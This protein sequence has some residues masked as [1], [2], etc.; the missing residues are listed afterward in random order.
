MVG[1]V[2]TVD[3]NDRQEK[4]MVDFRRKLKREESDC[5]AACVEFA[6]HLRTNFNILKGHQFAAR[7]FVFDLTKE[8]RL[9]YPDLSLQVIQRV[10]RRERNQDCLEDNR[11]LMVENSIRDACVR[12]PGY[13]IENV[14]GSGTFGTVFLAARLPDKAIRLAIKVVWKGDEESEFTSMTAVQDSPYVIK[15]FDKTWTEQ[16]ETAIVMELAT[17]SLAAL[18]AKGVPSSQEIEDVVRGLCRG[19]RYCHGEGVIHH[20]LKPQNV[21]LCEGEVKLT[22]FG[23]SL[24]REPQI[25][26][27]GNPTIKL[28]YLAGTPAYMSPEQICRRGREGND[29]WALGVIIIELVTGKHPFA[30]A[31]GGPREELLAAI[32]KC[33]YE[34]ARPNSIR[35][36][37]S[38]QKFQQFASQCFA[39]DEAD[40]FEDVGQLRDAF[41]EWWTSRPRNWLDRFQE[42]LD[43][44]WTSK[45]RNWAGFLIM[46]CFTAAIL[47]FVMLLGVIPSI[48]ENRSM[49]PNQGIVVRADVSEIEWHSIDDG[50]STF[51][52]SDPI[53]EAQIDAGGT[54]DVVLIPAVEVDGYCQELG[55]E[56]EAEL[57]LPTGA[58][59]DAA[60]RHES[61]VGHEGGEWTSDFE[62]GVR[63]AW[64]EGHGSFRGST[65]RYS[66]R[67]ASETPQKDE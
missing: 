6:N 51:W 56:F 33:E 17:S 28:D 67:L 13:E 1:A 11:W 45:W 2:S 24:K 23:V 20:D 50:N 64:R 19:V 42:A 32:E 48:G 66:F 22:D 8:L 43:R 27:A 14:I 57:T 36:E 58:Q 4:I 52:I 54:G 34:L 9:L 15:I 29:V 46:T 59:L 47:V 39:L 62:D 41:N 26:D 60:S 3:E 12:V 16:G 35:K 40:R 63:C 49:T 10:L 44:W 38:E 5:E 65:N 18:E 30:N 61:F 53:T 7:Q 37:R 55:K 31:C 25:V 21:L